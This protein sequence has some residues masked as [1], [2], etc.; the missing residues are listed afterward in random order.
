MK[1][2]LFDSAKTG[3]AIYGV[4]QSVLFVWDLFG[5]QSLEKF[6]LPTFPGSLAICMALGVGWV[7]ARARSS[8]PTL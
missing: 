7:F 6:A 3:F 8:G 4:V 1:R 2:K 5:G